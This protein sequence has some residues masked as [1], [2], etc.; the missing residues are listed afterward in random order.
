MTENTKPYHHGN[1][2][3]ALIESALVELE[4]KGLE[5]LSLRSIAAR[6]GVSHT[7]PKN[8]FRNL[9]D[10]LTSVALAGF[11]G[12]AAEMRRS[13]SKQR[14]PQ[15]RRLE[16]CR[17]YVRFAITHPEL[18]RLM[19]SK[20]HCN[21]D[22]AQLQEA[23]GFTQDVLRRITSDSS[24]PNSRSGPSDTVLWSLI[25]GYATLAVQG[26]VD[27]LPEGALSLDMEDILRDFVAPKAA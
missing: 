19:Y 25:H 9:R 15:A 18:F 11:M 23:A 7:A 8:H 6:A 16:A 22:D 17:S 2:R 3:A 12:Q 20:F 27:A 14:V 21:L 13:V 1:L 5:T 10:L 4:E 24:G 26:H